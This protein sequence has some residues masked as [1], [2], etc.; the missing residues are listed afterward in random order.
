MRQFT[1]MEATTIEEASKNASKGNAMVIAGGTD[2]LGTLKDEILPT[3]PSM[4]IDLKTIKDLDK[5][6][7]KKDQVI[8]GALAKLADVADSQM[9]RNNCQAL[10][11]ACGKVASPTIRNMATLGGNICQMHRCWYFRTPDNRFH[12]GRK[13]GSTCPAYNGDNRYHSIFGQQNGCVAASSHD[14]APALIALGAVIVTSSRAVLAEEFFA[15][16]GFRSCILE[17]GEIVTHIRVP[18]SKKSVFEKF[19]LRKSIDFPIVNCAAAYDADGTVRVAM[20]GVYPAPLRIKAAEAAVAGG[21][22]ESTAK[23]AGDDAV[24]D[25]APLSGTAYKVEIARTMVKRTLLRLEG[26]R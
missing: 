3:Y 16:N 6:E 7:E 18:K 12:C 13:G 2:L 20:G 10:A 23:K 21:I 5:I 14:T 19:A 1:H 25:C 17:D 9:V 15:A 4:I 8:I 22:T 11:E 24:A 26:E